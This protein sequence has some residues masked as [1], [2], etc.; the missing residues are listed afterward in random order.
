[1][2][3]DGYDGIGYYG[4]ISLD[5]PAVSEA[6]HV[7]I[8]GCGGTL[9]AR[10]PARERIEQPVIDD[11]S[12]DDQGIQIAWQEPSFTAR[13][14]VGSFNGYSGRTCDVLPGAVLRTPDPHFF[15]TLDVTALQ[16][17]DHVEGTVG[18]VDVWDPASTS[19]A[20]DV[21]YPPVDDDGRW[22][23]AVAYWNHAPSATIELTVDG[24]SSNGRLDSLQASIAPDRPPD[25]SARVSGRVAYE[26]QWG[27][28]IEFHAGSET[29]QIV[30][31][32]GAVTF[33][34]PVDHRPPIDGLVLGSP[35]DE[36]YEVEVGPA[37]L[38][39]VTDA[40]S[41]ITVSFRLRLSL[42]VVARPEG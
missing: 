39:D 16:L 3:L 19:T 10:L 26:Q 15:G 25:E 30:L 7:S 12:F 2:D 24:E 6:S 28:R 5:L 20:G 4:V 34:G 8:I 23:L 9:R 29:D 31:E 32:R 1:M 41:T 17:V 27:E 33:S 21:L 37:V 35:E 36:F 13:A 18:T 42:G 22:S 40:A 14:H 38:V 11:V